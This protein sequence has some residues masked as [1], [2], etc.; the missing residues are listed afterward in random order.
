MAKKELTNK[1]FYWTDKEQHISGTIGGE[2]YE[3]T[4]SSYLVRSETDDPHLQFPSLVS[5]LFLMPTCH[6]HDELSVAQYQDFVISIKQ[7]QERVHD[8]DFE[9]PLRSDF[10][11]KKI[12]CPLWNQEGT[13]VS[14][15]TLAKSRMFKSLLEATKRDDLADYR[16]KWIN[17]FDNALELSFN[18]SKQPIRQSYDVLGR[19]FLSQNATYRLYLAPG[20]WLDGTAVSKDSLEEAYTHSMK[21]SHRTGVEPIL[22]L[23]AP[24]EPET[25]HGELI[26]LS[27]NPLGLYTTW[28]ALADLPALIKAQTSNRGTWLQKGPDSTTA[29]RFSENLFPRD[30]MTKFRKVNTESLIQYPGEKL[31]QYRRIT[32]KTIMG[33]ESAN[34]VLSPT[35]AANAPPD[36]PSFSGLNFL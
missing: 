22:L 19:F 2:K 26:K 34:I 33:N 27:S 35:A 3:L 20:K 28:I 23:N 18:M 14:Q 4:L 5:I 21:S 9:K 8:E 25:H 32:P 1:K 13:P 29:K 24:D 16:R 31:V 17:C 12:L 11:S 30:E 36:A 6:E 7:F 10:R 15:D